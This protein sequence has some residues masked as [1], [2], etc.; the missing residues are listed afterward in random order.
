MKITDNFNITTLF[1]RKEVIMTIE[2]QGN[3]TIHAKTVRNFFE[4]FSWNS[5]YKL[6]T[7][8][9]NEWHTMFKGIKFDTTYE[10]IQFL[11]FQIGHYKQYW[12]IA[13]SIQKYFNEIFD[14]TTIDFHNKTIE[15]NGITLTSEIWNY[16]VYLLKLIQ[17]EKVTQPRTFSSEAEAAFYRKQ[18]EYEQ[19]IQEIRQKGKNNN[20]DKE[21]LIKTCL[22]V[23]YS[24]PSITLDY[25]FDQTMAQIYWLQKMAAESVS[26]SFNEKAFA[27]GNVKKGKKLDF[28]IK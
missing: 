9:I 27:A 13:T 17:G 28:F 16:I 21:G 2:G 5:V 8:P 25:L 22:Y 15:I 1:L 3:I 10:Y 24:F 4:D 14:N 19:R 6:W 12:D 23:I 7:M 26:Y 20:G 11:V 18:M